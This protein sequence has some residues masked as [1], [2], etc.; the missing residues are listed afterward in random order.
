MCPKS[1]GNT[2]EDGKEAFLVRMA[3]NFLLEEYDA[4]VDEVRS[5]GLAHTAGEAG[6]RTIISPLWNNSNDYRKVVLRKPIQERPSLPSQSERR[7]YGCGCVGHLRGDPECSAG[8]KAVWMGAP[9]RFKRKVEEGDQPLLDRGERKVS[10]NQQKISNGKRR[11]A[12]S[13]LPCRN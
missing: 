4:A 13:K 1:G 3:V 7:C 10:S 5:M 12:A 6:T 8:D 9:E 11:I 2:Y